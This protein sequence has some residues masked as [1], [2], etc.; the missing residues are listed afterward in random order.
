MPPSDDWEKQMC[1]IISKHRKLGK[2]KAIVIV[3]EGARDRFLN[4]IS[5]TKVKDLLS[6]DLKLDTRITTLG[7][8]QRGGNACAYDQ[9]LS[10]LQGVEAV[11]AVLDATP[12]TPT[13]VIAIIENKIG[14]EPLIEAVKLTHEVAEA[15]EAKDF[16]R[17]M[18]LR[19]AEFAE[20]HSAYMATTATDQPK[21][22]LPKEKARNILLFGLS[23]GATAVY[24]PEEGI[25]IKMLARD[26]EHLRESFAKDKG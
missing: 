13:P 8:V 10:T 25:D 23:I 24:T 4:K 9:M 3:A 14:R 18:G 22:M 15:I 11:D 19:D 6:N 5:P 16:D 2:R 26:I 1:D 21:L 7:H 20:Y 17:A 12:E